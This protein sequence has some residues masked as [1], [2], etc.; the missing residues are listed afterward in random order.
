MKK[1]ENLTSKIRQ[2]A[3][4]LEERQ[5]YFFHN[6]SLSRDSSDNGREFV[7]TETHFSASNVSNMF[8]HGKTPDLDKISTIGLYKPKIRNESSIKATSNKART[9]NSSHDQTTDAFFPVDFS[10]ENCFK[11]LL[12]IRSEADDRPVCRFDMDACLNSTTI[13]KYYPDFR[14]E[15]LTEGMELEDGS[16]APCECRPSQTIAIIVPFRDRA[17]HLNIWLRNI[18]AQLQFQRRAF[19][20]VVAEQTTSSLFNRASLFNAAFLVLNRTLPNFYDCVVIHDVDMLPE[21]LCT[22]YQC[23]GNPLH[24]SVEV[25]KFDFRMPYKMYAGGILSMQ[26]STV[27]SFNGMS[28]LYFGWGGE[29]DNLYGRFLVNKLSLERYHDTRLRH[30]LIL[31]H[32]KNKKVDPR[33]SIRKVVLCPIR[34]YT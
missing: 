18:I 3:E 11:H 19:S 15:P 26:R 24:L 1:F 12:L 13:G 28:N 10:T 21:S 8:L 22:L 5:R 17:A 31:K 4:N 20:I 16:W 27:T 30:T 14:D 23:H 29:D 7:A 32:V 33:R 34:V 25:E 9:R 2:K 6:L